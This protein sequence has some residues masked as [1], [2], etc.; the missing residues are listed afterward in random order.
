V[1]A[2]LTRRLRAGC[3]AS[4]DLHGVLQIPN[5]LSKEL[6]DDLNALLDE[7]IATDTDDDWRTLRFPVS[8]GRPGAQTEAP[9]SLLDWG[10]PIRDCLAVPGIVDMCDAIIG[11]R[12][13]LDHIYLDVIR[14][15]EADTVDAAGGNQQPGPIANGLH[16]S[17]GGFDPAQY[18]HYENGQMFSECSRYPATYSVRAACDSRRRRATASFLST[19]AAGSPT[20]LRG[21]G[22]LRLLAQMACLSS[23]STSTPWTLRT[24]VASRASLGRTRATTTSRQTGATCK[25]AFIRSCSASAGRRDRQSSSRRP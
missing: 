6:V 14:P 4:Q 25:R 9:Q 23:R 1:A 16:G 22:W 5:A 15:P 3:L 17:S 7:H 18:Y 24:T 12:F 10:K 2:G 13:R 8:D 11:K 20:T 19:D 21:A